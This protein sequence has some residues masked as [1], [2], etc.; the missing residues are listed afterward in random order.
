MAAVEAGW[1]GRPIG[2]SVVMAS[3]GMEHWH[4]TPEFFYQPG[5]GP[6]LDVGPYY[7]TQLVNLIGPVAKVTALA[8]TPLASRYVTS[9]PGPARDIPVGVATTVNAALLMA[10]GANVS[11]TMSWD[12]WKH[13]R[14]PIEIYGTEGTLLNPDPNFFIGGYLA[15]EKTMLSARGGDWV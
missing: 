1:I 4:S 15:P 5:G 8:S 11:L 6:L 14:R 9:P 13:A 12:V 2:G 10:N 3:H 7:L